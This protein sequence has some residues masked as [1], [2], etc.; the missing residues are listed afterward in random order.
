MK[1]NYAYSAA[2]DSDMETETRRIQPTLK[3]TNRKPL[4]SSAQEMTG[5]AECLLDI[6]EEC[7]LSSEE[8]CRLIDQESNIYDI[9]M[10]NEGKWH[11]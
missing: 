7:S 8:A 9:A 2:I 10:S 4:P 11:D 5:Y 3:L 1:S 6:H